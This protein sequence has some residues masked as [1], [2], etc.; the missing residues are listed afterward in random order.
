MNRKTCAAAAIA[1]ASLVATPSV[2]GTETRDGIP[3]TQLLCRATGPEAIGIIKEQV[4]LVRFTSLLVGVRL[5]A[6]TRGEAEVFH[7]RSQD[8]TRIVASV[9]IAGKDLYKGVQINRLTGEMRFLWEVEKGP[10]RQKLWNDAKQ[11]MGG[12]DEQAELQFVSTP[13]DC[14]PAQKK[15]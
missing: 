5:I 1:L 3:V 4:W 9:Q 12:F 8:D 2:A 6:P 14:Q 13:Y 7:I 15:F 11:Q 10:E